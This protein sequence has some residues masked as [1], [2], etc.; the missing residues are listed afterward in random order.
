MSIANEILNYVFN[1]WIGLA[2]FFAILVSKSIYQVPQGYAYIVERFGKYNKTLNAG[3]NFII[4]LIDRIADKRLLKEQAVNVDPQTAITADNITLSIDGVLYFKVIDPERATYGVDNYVFALS[5]LAQTTMRAE[6]GK[7]ELDKTFEERDMLNTNIVASINKAAE[8][9]GVTAMRYEIRDIDPPA[10]V[11]SAMEQ[12]MKA[13]REK[14]AK[15]LESEGEKQAAINRAEGEKQ[16]AIKAAEAD[17]QEQELRA[18]GEAAA[19]LAV[20]EAKAQ[21]IRQIGE[22]ANSPEG[23]KAVQLDLATKAIE[24]KQAIAKEGTVVLLDGAKSEAGATVAEA[25]SIV[26]AMNKSDAFSA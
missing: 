4:P 17:K 10:S 12:Q 1:F 14:R 24:A 20:A 9:W 8:P 23:Q 7:L 26:A 2:I 18:Q 6:I 11:M 25:I 19:I 21:A 3:L 22:A 5:N 16:A 13:E 15:I